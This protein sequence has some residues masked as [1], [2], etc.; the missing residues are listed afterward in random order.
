[1]A[2][3]IV[4]DCALLSGRA[5]RAPLILSLVLGIR[6]SEGEVHWQVGGWVSRGRGEKVGW[7]GGVL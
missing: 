4:S 3:C 2:A 7:V 1:M 6:L 5:A